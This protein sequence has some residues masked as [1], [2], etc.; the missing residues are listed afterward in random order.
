ML[1]GIEERVKEIEKAVD[2]HV[3]QLSMDKQA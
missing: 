3:Q 1:E 2:R